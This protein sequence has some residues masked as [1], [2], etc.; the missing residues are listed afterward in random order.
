MTVLCAVNTPD[1]I[2]IGSDSQGTITRTY[3]VLENL[4][5]YFDRNNGQK[6]KIGADGHPLLNNWSKVVC[7]SSEVPCKS[8][9]EVDKLFSLDPLK[10]GVMICG[11]SAIGDRS[12][13]SLIREFKDTAGFNRLCCSDYT[14]KTTAAELLSFLGQ[15]YMEIYPYEPHPE[16]ELMICGYDKNRYTPGVVRIYV[17]LANITEPDYDFCIFFGGITR[18]IQRLLFGIDSQNKRRL[19]ERNQQLL[20][21]YHSLL[22]RQV[23]KDGSNITLK[24]P[25]E[26]GNELHLFDGWQLERLQMNCGMYSEHT[27]VEC[28]EFLIN[29]MIK[30]QKFSNQV[31]STGGDAQ[32]AII[33]K[34]S[35]FRY[36]TPRQWYLV[37]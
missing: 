32:I 4:S 19:I 27:A 17:H 29:I 6:L 35:G 15:Q 36:I 16:L 14:L 7:Q 31:P 11:L 2:V 10:M 13:K 23:Q 37:D 30:T 3:V 34:N 24:H 9:T 28:I 18:E 33:R 21:R 25:S 20:E 12:I 1:A 5:D 22:S 26:F 8:H